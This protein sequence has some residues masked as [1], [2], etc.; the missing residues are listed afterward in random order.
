MKLFFL[1]LL[2]LCTTALIAQNAA[3]PSS[4]DWEILLS[5]NQCLIEYPENRVLKS[6][7]E[8]EALWSRAFAKMDVPPDKPEVDFGKYHVVTI[9]LGWKKNGGFI[10]EIEKISTLRGDTNIHFLE[11]EPGASC[12]S[13]A[14]IDFPFLLVRIPINEK[15]VYFFD[16]KKMVYDC[17]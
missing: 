9:F 16:H 7:K 13:T 17:Q 6:T 5:G 8:F 4:M 10:L 15:D 3:T 1:L 12:I 14:S 11:K 2:S